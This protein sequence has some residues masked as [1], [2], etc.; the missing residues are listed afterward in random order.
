MPQVAA[1]LAAGVV[2]A[3]A[4]PPVDEAPPPAELLLYLVEF[5]DAR[6]DPVDPIELPP[7]TADPCLSPATCPTANPT[8]DAEH[9][10]PPR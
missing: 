9:P 2:C 6:G 8:D 10:A 5:V 7:G 3:A 4:P 1:W